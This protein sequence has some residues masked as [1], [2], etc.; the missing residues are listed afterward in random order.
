MKNADTQVV[1]WTQSLDPMEEDIIQLSGELLP[2]AGDTR[3]PD[4]V[5]RITAAA[6]SG[7]RV[8]VG[9]DAWVTRHKDVI[10]SEL[11]T[12]AS[13]GQPGAPIVMAVWAT[14]G[15]V[16]VEVEELVTALTAFGRQAGYELDATLAMRAMEQVV[17][18]T[19]PAPFRP[20]RW[21]RAAA[22]RAWAGISLAW[23]WLCA[24]ARW[25][26]ATSARPRATIRTLVKK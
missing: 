18:S 1:F 12:S 25:L 4:L 13:D 7:Q 21:P 2:P 24:A 20:G 14:R 17:Q 6:E 8:G 3:R 11:P 19:Q 16:R 5:H 23:L 9:D 26:W 10:V 22:R 15:K